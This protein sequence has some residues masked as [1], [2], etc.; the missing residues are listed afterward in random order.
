MITVPLDKPEIYN[1]NSTCDSVSFSWNRDTQNYIE[2]SSY[3]VT[4][5]QSADQVQVKTEFVSS[6]TSQALY[7]GL[8]E[9]TEYELAVKQKTDVDNIGYESSKKTITPSCMF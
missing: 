6:N 8:E 7:T 5:T 9:N 1:V 2:V 4:V 3:Q